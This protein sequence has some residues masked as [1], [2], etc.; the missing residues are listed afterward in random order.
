MSDDSKGADAEK[1]EASEKLFDKFPTTVKELGSLLVKING[2][3]EE[4][5]SNIGQELSTLK[6][7]VGHMSNCFDSFKKS[8]EEAQRQLQEVHTEQSR[9]K[10]E[11]RALKT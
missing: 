10:S 11:N 3:M 5:S 9:L 4:M 1:K 7:S 2:K 8:L 6:E